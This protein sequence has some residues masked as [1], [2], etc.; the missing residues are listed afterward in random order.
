MLQNS[1]NKPLQEQLLIQFLQNHDEHRIGCVSLSRKWD[2]F[3]FVPLADVFYG[4]PK[5][6]LHQVKSMKD[7][8][9]VVEADHPAFNSVNPTWIDAVNTA[10]QNSVPNSQL[11]FLDVGLFVGMVS[12]HANKHLHPGKTTF[13]CVEPNPANEVIARLNLG[14]N[15]VEATVVSAACSDEDGE[16]S[17]WVPKGVLISGRISTRADRHTY[18][19]QTRRI[20]SLL[21]GLN[22]SFDNAVIKIDTEG[23]EWS[24]LRGIDPATMAKTLA[25][26]LEYWPTESLE[27]ERYLIENFRVFNL[28]SAM[29]SSRLPYEEFESASSLAQV[30]EDKIQSH[31]NFDVLLVPRVGRSKAHQELCR[32]IKSEG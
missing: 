27:Y 28:K 7:W 21:K 18:T 23:A 2:Y 30:A 11:L 9:K 31:Q 8:F 10:L 19:V 5:F 14:M 24:V 32:V 3:Y 13:I 17:F 6:G 25:I 1:D 26:V 4:D 20:D 12:L 29:F 22:P 15:G 16:A